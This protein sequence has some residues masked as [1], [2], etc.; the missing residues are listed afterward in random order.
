MVSITPGSAA[1][2]SSRT[3]P[4][5]VAVAIWAVA[6]VDGAHSIKMAKR[7]H[8]QRFQMRMVDLARVHEVYVTHQLERSVTSPAVGRV[9]RRA[10]ALARRADQ[11][12]QRAV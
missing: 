10:L 1:P 3:L 12:C 5:S 9:G 11:H 6:P 7:Q 2:V 4:A 8:S